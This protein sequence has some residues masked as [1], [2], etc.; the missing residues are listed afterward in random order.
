MTDGKKT[1]FILI[2]YGL[3]ENIINFNRVNNLLK[4]Q[5]RKKGLK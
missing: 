4:N 2:D 1:F 3:K 5:I